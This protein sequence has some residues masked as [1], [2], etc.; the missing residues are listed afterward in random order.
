MVVGTV[1]GTVAGV[2]FGVG[3]GAGG[4]G[5]GFG[6]TIGRPAS[7]TVH[8]RFVFLSRYAPAPYERFAERIAFLYSAFLR[9]VFTICDFDFTFFFDTRTM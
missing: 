2:G 4:F 8:A 3:W 9:V 6:F 7:M 5:A 1:V